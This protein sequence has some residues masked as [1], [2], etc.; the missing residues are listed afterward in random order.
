MPTEQLSILRLIA[1]ASL[2]VQLV[3]AVALPF[4]AIALTRWRGL[5]SA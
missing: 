4:A 3:L 1:D 2:I 5:R